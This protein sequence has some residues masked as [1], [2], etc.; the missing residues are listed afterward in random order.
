I[1]VAGDHLLR[2]VF[3]PQSVYG[4]VVASQWRWLEHAAW[5]VFEDVFLIVASLRSQN[6]M[7]QTAERT[8]MLE[9]EVRTRHHAEQELAQYTRE[10]E[11]AHDNERRNAEQL[12]TLVSELRVTQRKAESAT[13]AKSDFLASMSHELRTPLNAII[14]Y[15]ELLQ[16]DAEDRADTRPV[17][18]LRRIHTAGTH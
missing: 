6:E 1:V 17:A 12:E 11:V 13:R 9:E 16:E 2:G 14:L 8:A 18:D 10:L 3:W 4:V 15:S 5:V 7:R